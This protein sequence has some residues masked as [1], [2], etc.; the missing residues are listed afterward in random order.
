MIQRFYFSVLLL[1]AGCGTDSTLVSNRAPQAFAGFD[2]TVLAGSDV[3]LD[4]SGSSDPDGNGLTYA[5]RIRQPGGEV[6]LAGADQTFP[7]LSIPVGFAGHVVVELVVSDGAAPSDPDWVALTV[8]APEEAPA[9][10]ADAGANRFHPEDSGA[11]NLSA[12]ASSAPPGA[13]VR[14][15]HMRAPDGIQRTLGGSSEQSV[16]SLAAGTHVFSLSMGVGSRWS[17]PDF[18]TVFVG[19]SPPAGDFPAVDAPG[20]ATSGSTIDL[21]ASAANTA[22]WVLISSPTGASEHLETRPDGSTQLALAD[23]GMYVVSVTNEHGMTDW[24]AVVAE[25]P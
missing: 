1:S 22:T 8:L 6:G 17:A 23:P 9:L 25:A 16:G 10:V 11:L 4:G 15:V 2:Q 20:E 18:V 21:T 5:W 3:L 12:A 13:D 24:V 7:T 14:W 19:F